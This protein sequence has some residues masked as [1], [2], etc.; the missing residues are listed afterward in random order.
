MTSVSNIFVRNLVVIGVM[1]SSLLACT[2][3]RQATSRLD[4]PLQQRLDTPQA[5]GSA[6]VGLTDFVGFIATA[7]KVPL[8]VETIRPAPDVAV[9]AGT[10]TARQLLDI[11][12]RQLPGYE[13]K[14]EHGVAHLYQTELAASKGNLLNVEIHRYS[15][16]NNVADFDYG[17]RPCVYSIVKGYGCAG[18]AYSGFKSIELQKEILPEFESFKE[19][20]ARAVLLRALQANGHFYVLIVFESTHPQ[21]AS[22]FPFLNWYTRSLVPQDFRVLGLHVMWPVLAS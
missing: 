9:P 19:V 10:Y 13:W 11:A 4:L 16:P 1:A 5:V 3:H 14:G 6:T 2:G 7:Y 8:L 12:V 17:F 21:L 18:G 20:T 15:F 22:D